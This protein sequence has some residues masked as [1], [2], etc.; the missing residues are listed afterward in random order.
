MAAVVTA[1]SG[2]DLG[3]VWKGQGAKAQPEQSAG[4]Y[5]INAAQEGEPPGRWWGPGAEALGFETGQVVER[6]PYEKVYRQIDPRTGDRMGRSPGNYDAFADWLVKLKAAEPYATAERLIELEREAARRARTAP[7]YIDMT[8]SFSKSISVF[9]ASIREN[10]RRARL[11]GDEA[12]A[13]YWGEAE[14]RYQ[15]V[16][17]AANRTG[18]E[19]VQ[20]W[21][22]IT[23]TGYHGT[24]VDGKELGRFE[25]AL[26]TVTSWLQG[27]SRDGDPQ[28]HVHNQI[29]RIVETVSDGKH[30]ALDTATL[31]QVLGAVQAVVATHAEC[32]LTR[33]FGVTWTPRKDGIGNEISGVTQA[34]IDAYSSRAASIAG[35]LPKAV[36]AWTAKYGR[37]PNQR[38][39]LFIQNEVTLTTRQGKEEGA[40]DWDALCLQ[41]E[42]KW[43][44]EW[45]PGL[46]SVASRVSN[47]RGNGHLGKTRKAYAEPARQDLI[48]AA[49]RALSVVQGKHS[50]WTR[51]DYMKELAYVLPVGTRSMDPATAVALLDELANQALSGDVEQVVCMEAPEWPPLP[52]YLRRE[53]D[54]RSVYTRPGTTRYATRVQLGLEERLLRE[55]QR[56]GAPH[57]GRDRAAE[58]LGAEA[59]ELEEQLY[60]RAQESRSHATGSG[61]RLDQGAALYHAL[62][63]DRTVEVIVG[64]AGSGKTRTLAQASRAWINAGMGEVIGIATAQAARNVLASAGVR[65]AEN[66]S[67]FL[68]HMP[69]QRNARPVRKIG[70]GTLLV[71]DEASMMSMTDLEHIVSHATAN[72]AKVLICGDQEQLE[73]VESGG[74]MMLLARR[75]GH[76]QLAEAVRF[77]AQWE[78]DASLRLRAGDASVLDTYD[79]H[80]RVRGAEPEQA[81]SDAVRMY[82]ANYLAAGDTLLMIHDRERCR[83]ASRRIRDDLIHLGVVQRGPEVRLAD[84]ARASVGDLIICRDNDHTLEAGEPGRTLANGDTLR[85]E[86]ISD[87]GHIMVRRAL[88]CDPKTGT[89][90]FT[91]R[92]FT[93][94]DY[95]KAD[96]AYAVTGHSAQGRTVKIGIPLLTGTE[97][98]QW[99]YVAMTRGTDGNWAIV[100]T[101]SARQAEPEAGTRPAPELQR[102]QRIERERD[103]LPAGPVDS[104]ATPA[105]RHFTGVM[106]DMLDN[107]TAEESALET[108][109][110][111]LANADH[112]AKLNAYWQGETAELEANRYRKIVLAALPP[113]WTADGLN[114]R[115]ATW[116]WRT[117]RTAEAAGR[118][119]R[120]VVEEAVGEHALAGTRDVASVL[121]FRIR[122]KISSLVPQ[123]PRPW[124]ER[125]PEVTDPERQRFVAELAAAM[126]ARKERIGEHA[127]QYAPGWAVHALGP[128]PDDPLERLEWE[129]RASDVGA[130]RELYNYDHPTEPIG[131]E[132]TGDAPE[133]RA[134][135]HGAFVSMRPVDGPDFRSLP[136]GSLLHMHGTYETETAW[137]PRHVGRD[138][139]QVRSGAETASLET[140][141]AKAEERVARERGQED[142]AMRH[143][144]LARSYAAMEAAYRAQESELAEQMDVRR[145]WESATEDGRRQALAADSEYRRR[146]PEQKLEPLRSAEPV[147]TDAE[148]SL[149]ELVP[150]A[151]TYK[152]P[153]WVTRLAEE[154]RAVREKLDERKGVR[155]PHEDPDYQDLGEAWPA[156][157]ERQRD[158]I[159]QPP[160][161]EMRPAPEVERA[162]EAQAEAEAHEA[163]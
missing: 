26:I 93:Y 96:L 141:R 50:T 30:R 68:G 42:A 88:D 134:A 8:V 138:L 43:D 31:R 160:K 145:E 99:L 54:G 127:A 114:S 89:R 1:V 116:L 9:H 111:E 35:E 41:W 14:A 10:E 23:R 120:E 51:A 44:T 128:V 67:I 80:G 11:A 131:P 115:Q 133:K 135:W 151:E 121:N 159:L 58:L 59:A 72:G 129:R 98:R 157:H 143:G 62:T 53:L 70:P 84:G 161:P 65:V 36:A 60:E 79:E 124:S 156:W 142:R 63:S 117:L 113:E 61:L 94:R 83:E 82:V 57:L 75:L 91:E 122:Q 73:A 101:K 27:T 86:S 5:Y 76:V 21:A 105:P 152:T 25:A 140:V 95:G 7:A 154:R 6:E 149:L 108:H 153:E 90:N 20:K 38:E 119:A 39:L 37:E 87:Q 100:F 162:A 123:P 46:A 52:G 3:Y 17:Q 92:A 71:I 125:V 130:Y 102:H 34:Q 147:V 47:L 137:A 22:G 85:I 104:S 106:A 78:R 126:D 107:S 66:S 136:D 56:R 97:S 55:A 69:G 4:G 19:Y 144:L 2:Y 24:K 110:Q 15:E 48:R 148:H 109:R 33:E 112:L 150:G 146:H 45:G 16:V 74:G 139:R 12:A 18:L 81:M 32:G 13:A 163:V 118:D 40:I 29:A 132:P 64:P 77:K 28:D 158:A 155:V 49:Q 103:G